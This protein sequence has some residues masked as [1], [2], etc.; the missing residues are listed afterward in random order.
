MF[1][2]SCVFALLCDNVRPALIDSSSQSA[3]LKIDIASPA[4]LKIRRMGNQAKRS[5]EVFQQ[6][7]TSESEIPWSKEEIMLEY[8]AISAAGRRRVV[9]TRQSLSRSTTKSESSIL[10]FDVD[11]YQ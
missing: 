2:Y 3:I 9:L 4:Q 11:L 6:L 8:D 5:L 1:H 10:L 7:M